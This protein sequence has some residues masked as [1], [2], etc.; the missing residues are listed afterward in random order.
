[1][2]AFLPAMT[3]AFIAAGATAQDFGLNT[4]GAVSGS[5]DIRLPEVNFR[6]NWP[7]LGG[8]TVLGEAAADGMHVVYTQPGVIE[9]YLETGT[10]PDGAVL[11]KELLS[12]QTEEM[13]TGTVARGDQVQGWF[14]M[15]KDTQGRFDGNPLWGDGWGWAFFNADAPTRTVTTNYQDDCV[16]CHVPAETTDWIYTQ[17][18]P[19]LTSG[20]N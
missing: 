1:M 14:V 12:A 2:K 17:G 16:A 19:V 10:F 5:G 6:A 13:T 18:Y 4:H 7:V 9:A 15:V 20:G 3:V 11:V 8:W